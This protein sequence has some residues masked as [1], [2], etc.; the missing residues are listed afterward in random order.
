VTV[1]GVRVG[2][3]TSEPARTRIEKAFGRPLRLAFGQKRWRISPRYLGANAAVDAA[4]ARTLRAPPRAR[5]NLVV[6]P[7]KARIRR[8][9]RRLD[10][11]F[12]REPVNATVVGVSG[13]RSG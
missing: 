5:V 6:T 10:R 3:L 9:V 11:I 12:S 1:A 13:S 4:V 7:T 2:G 8:Y